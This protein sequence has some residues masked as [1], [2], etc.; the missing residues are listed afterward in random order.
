MA[1]WLQGIETAVPETVYTQQESAARV[2]GWMTD[3]RERRLSTMAHKASGIEKRHSV[4]TSFE[5]DFFERCRTPPHVIGGDDLV[6]THRLDEFG[7]V[8]SVEHLFQVGFCCHEV[9]FCRGHIFRTHAHYQIGK[10]GACNVQSCLRHGNLF[11][12]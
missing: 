1:V 5:D 10:I 7:I 3:P 8:G 11:Y 9:G 2:A 4:I 6:P 12:P